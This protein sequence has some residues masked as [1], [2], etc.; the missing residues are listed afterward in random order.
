MCGCGV[1]KEIRVGFDD[2]IFYFTTDRRRRLKRRMRIKN[3]Y[4]RFDV[5]TQTHTHTHTNT[6]KLNFIRTH[7]NLHIIITI[8]IIRHHL[9]SRRSR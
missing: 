4:Y 5:Y 9:S 3:K 8:I 6:E 1:K 2:I 7:F